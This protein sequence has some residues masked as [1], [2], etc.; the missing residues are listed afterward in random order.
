MANMNGPYLDRTKSIYTHHAAGDHAV[1]I[2]A[3][4]VVLFC[5]ASAAYSLC[6]EV[7]ASSEPGVQLDL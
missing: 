1:T 3:A 2:V 7:D 5:A 6:L 4:A